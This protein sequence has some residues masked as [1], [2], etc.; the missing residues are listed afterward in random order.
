MFC[1]SQVSNCYSTL[2]R[3]Y[4]AFQE[5]LC[6]R[7]RTIHELERKMEEKERELHTIKLDNEAVRCAS[8]FILFIKKIVLTAINF[9]SIFC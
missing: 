6:E 2:K 4:L 3:V 1:F 9:D 5:Q 7:E 8:F